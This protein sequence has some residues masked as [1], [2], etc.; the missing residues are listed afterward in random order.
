MASCPARWPRR[1]LR[2]RGRWRRR[3]TSGG[4]SGGAWG[5]C[6]GSTQSHPW[7]TPSRFLCLK[8]PGWK[9]PPA[10][11]HGVAPSLPFSC[12]LDNFFKTVDSLIR[13]DFHFHFLVSSSSMKILYITED[14][15]DVCDGC[16][17]DDVEEDDKFS[18]K[19]SW[20][21]LQSSLLS[22]LSHWGVLGSLRKWCGVAADCGL[23][24]LQSHNRHHDHHNHHHHHLAV[25]DNGVWWLDGGRREWVSLFSNNQVNG[26]GCGVKCSAPVKISKD[27][28]QF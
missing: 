3:W 12:R 6:S 18:L 9:L 25:Q 28:V 24:K 20:W 21:W 5:I 11:A 16:K 10:P 17:I 27:G 13:T 14:C 23:M 22:S 1:R 4:G 2:R 15:W 7:L 8:P 26:K 19:Q